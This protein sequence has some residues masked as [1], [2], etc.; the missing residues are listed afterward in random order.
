MKQE[1]INTLRQMRD[2][3][4][5]VIIWTP[6]ELNGAHPSDIEDGSIQFASEYLIPEPETETGED[7]AQFYGPSA[8]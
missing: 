5:A 6:E 8:R 7:L 3:G 2:A 1:W 4:Y